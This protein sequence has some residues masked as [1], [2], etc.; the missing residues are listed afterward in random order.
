MLAAHADLPLLIDRSEVPN[1]TFMANSSAPL[2][3]D[4]VCMG[5]SPTESW[6]FCSLVI[7]TGEGTMDP[8]QL[9]DQS[10]RKTPLPLID[11]NLP[12]ETTQLLD[13]LTKNKATTERHIFAERLRG[14][15]ATYYGTAGHAFVKRLVA[16]M[17]EHKA[18]LVTRIQRDIAELLAIV[19]LDVNDELQ[20]RRGKLFGLAYAAGLLA[21]DYKVLPWDRSLLKRSI[22]RCCRCIPGQS[23][24]PEDPI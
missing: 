11:V 8:L 18:K 21:I 24:M 19:H 16:D 6:E 12:S 20:L 23:G 7:S 15:A 13:R 2:S 14:N 4:G 3:S 22:R 5:V 9:S 17:A 1:A 10:P